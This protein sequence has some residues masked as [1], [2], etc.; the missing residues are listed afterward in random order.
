MSVKIKMEKKEGDDTGMQTRVWGPAGWIFLHSIAQNYPWEPTAEK[1]EYYKLFFRLIGEVLPCRYCRE[2]YQHF[3]KEQGTCLD[4]SVLKDRKTLTT[5]LYKI[6][7][8][9]NKKLGYKF[10]PT[11]KETWD[12]YESYRSKCTKSP[13]ILE[14]IQKGCLDPLKGYRKKCIFKVINV[15]SNG[16]PIKKLHF[17][18][19]KGSSKKI[20]LV[21]IKKSNKS[22]KK[23]MATFET[24]GRKKVIH[25]GAAGMS[26]FTKHHD[27]ERRNRYITRHSKDL[28]TGNPARAG[29]LSM[30]VLWNKP[31]LQASIRDYKRRLGIYNK[32][33]KFPKKI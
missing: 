24:N 3:I 21:S 18:K 16:E 33:G 15:D 5:W 14:K 12:K 19:P 11:L 22:G 4:D 6:H 20:K 1:K 32:T 27:R 23:L 26:D 25:F 10:I 9:V 31:S 7:N 2:S 28:R 29:Y 30:F 17:G 13:E 8:K